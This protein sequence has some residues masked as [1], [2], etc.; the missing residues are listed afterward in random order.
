M[1]SSMEERQNNGGLY[2]DSIALFGAIAYAKSLSNN[3]LI[4]LFG[5]PDYFTFLKSRLRAQAR[6][7]KF[8]NAFRIHGITYYY[9][10]NVSQ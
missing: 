6:Y 7:C 1:K 2:T 4:P 10:K 5:R 3:L 9:H 8:S